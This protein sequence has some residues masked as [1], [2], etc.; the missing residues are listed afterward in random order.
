MQQNKMDVMFGFFE[1][2]SRYSGI[3]PIALPEQYG[4]FRLYVGGK[5]NGLVDCNP[6]E[7]FTG[8]EPKEGEVNFFPDTRLQCLKTENIDL[9]GS[10]FIADQLRDLEIRFEPCSEKSGERKCANTKNFLQW[11]DNKQFF[12]WTAGNYM[13]PKGSIEADEA[14]QQRIVYQLSLTTT[15]GVKNEIYFDM[16]MSEVKT[17]NKGDYIF[18]TDKPEPKL[19]HRFLN[20]YRTLQRETTVDEKF[21]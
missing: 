5:E 4:A 13:D 16:D 20:S 3:S 10:G 18:G 1:Q 2:E 15:S 7:H 21:K 12:L 11:F 19:V 17:K 6:G 9:G 8:V 14:L